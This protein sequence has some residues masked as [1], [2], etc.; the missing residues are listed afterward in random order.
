MEKK[1]FLSNMTF[2]V[3][4]VKKTV[5]CCLN[6]KGQKI[7]AVA[8]CCENDVFDIEKGKLISCYRAEIKQRERDLSNTLTVISMLKMLIHKYNVINE[9]W[10]RSKH[11]DNFLRIACDEKKAQQENIKYCKKE[12]EKLIRE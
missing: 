11:W 1:K 10:K 4:E 3:N 9:P 6:S 2:E 8:K 5:T 12:L 7:Y